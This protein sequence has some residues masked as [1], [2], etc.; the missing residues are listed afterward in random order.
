MRR[1]S[2]GR[3]FV[4]RRQFE[5]CRDGRRRRG[6]LATGKPRTYDGRITGGT[7]THNGLLTGGRGAG[8]GQ[9]WTNPAIRRWAAAWRQHFTRRVEDNAPYHGRAG[10]GHAGAPA[11]A[12]FGLP[13][14]RFP[15]KQASAAHFVTLPRASDGRATGGT[16]AAGA[17]RPPYHGRTGGGAADNAHQTGNRSTNR[18]H[19]TPLKSSTTAD[20]QRFRIWG[21]DA[22][23]RVRRWLIN[24]PQRPQRAQG[25][26]L[27]KAK[28]PRP[29]DR[30]LDPS[31]LPEVA[32]QPPGVIQ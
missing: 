27:D 11:C 5:T 4:G 9:T 15:P 10:D 22:L 1:T 29:S 6:G 24:L 12:P 13:S 2:D 28:P 18:Y 21:R 19:R 20:G 26:V 16:R 30:G 32:G 23:P 25:A 3:A 14:A 8:F 31:V 17:G 7:R